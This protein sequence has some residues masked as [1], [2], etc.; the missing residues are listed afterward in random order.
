MA[1]FKRAVELGAYGIETD[2][3]RLFDGSLVMYHNTIFS[4]TGTS[5]YRFN[6]NTLR[7]KDADIPFFEDFLKYY[8]ETGRFLNIEIKDESGFVT[9]AGEDV[10]L[11]L[12]KYSMENKSIISSFNHN[13][14]IGIKRDYPEFKIGALYC[15]RYDLDV[16]DYCVRNSID[17]VHPQF[18]DVDAD[19]VEECHEHNIDVNVWTLNERADIIRMLDCN[20]DIIMTDNIAFAHSVMSEYYGK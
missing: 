20:V 19:F 8:S 17:A 16:I 13:T 4:D 10:A 14:I 7:E 3:H 1:A 18:S 9:N 11:L 2:V 6:E 5:I 12:K 15:K